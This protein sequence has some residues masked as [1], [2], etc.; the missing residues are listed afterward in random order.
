MRTSPDSP[1]FC[2]RSF[3]NP[4]DLFRLLRL[5]DEAEIADQLGED[6]SEAAIQE[7]LEAP[8]HDPDR[9]R[10]VVEHPDD[11]HVLIGQSSIWTATTDT[12]DLVA[13]LSLIVHPLWRRRGIGATL[14]QHSLARIQQLGASLARIYANPQHISAVRFLEAHQFHPVSAYTEMRADT[15]VAM[16]PAPDGFVIQSYATVNHAPTLVAAYNTCYAHQLGHHQVTADDVERSLSHLDPHG[17]FLM[18]TAATQ[19]L[20]GVCRS[21]HH[22]QRSAR[23]GQSTGYIDAP[24]IVPDYRTPDLYGALLLHAAQWLQRHDQVLELESWGDAPETIALYQTLGFTILH[25]QIA[26]QRELVYDDS[27]TR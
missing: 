21:A 24:G 16:R 22:P 17:L 9:D 26:Y 11:S 25:Q 12:N 14:L 3:Q 8:R 19:R 20:V 13:E 2:V 6:I 4:H 18:F 5:L 15:L 1:S 27:V 10:F 23:N 7:Q